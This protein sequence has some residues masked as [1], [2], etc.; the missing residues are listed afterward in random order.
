MQLED[1]DTLNF[2]YTLG[3]GN[4]GMVYRGVVKNL[5]TPAHSLY[6][7]PC[8]IP[9]AIKASWRLPKS[10]LLGTSASW[11][12]SWPSNLPHFR[13]WNTPTT[14]NY[15]KMFFVAM[16]TGFHMYELLPKHPKITQWCVG[17]AW[18]LHLMVSIYP[19]DPIGDQY[20]FWPSRLHYGGLLH[21]AISEL[22]YRPSLWRREQ[23]ITVVQC[24]NNEP[25]YRRQRQP[26]EPNEP[27]NTE[28]AASDP[29]TTS[30]LVHIF[31]GLA[32]LRW[33]GDEADSSKALPGTTTTMCWSHRC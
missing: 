24:G 6:A 14:A 13:H 1:I 20:C 5:R 21:E 25:W 18:K 19:V 9:A 7:Q 2:R 23:G 28:A 3:R 16:L 22:S 26:E 10:Y 31:E 33:G 27:A 15:S 11:V 32:D 30:L 12:I 4:F 17:I 29:P 8:E